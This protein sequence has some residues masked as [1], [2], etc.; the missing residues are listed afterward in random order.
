MSSGYTKVPAHGFNHEPKANKRFRKVSPE[1]PASNKKTIN[2]SKVLIRFIQ[3]PI[4][5]IISSLTPK[6]IRIMLT[7]IK[8]RFK[9]PSTYQGAAT[10]AGAIGYTINPEAWDL[11][12][13]AV[14]SVIGL[15]QMIKKEQKIIEKK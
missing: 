6:P 14:L 12:A 10:L 13:T 15:I 5:D 8:E 2:L 11:I 3:S 4:F 7:W 1:I 9:E